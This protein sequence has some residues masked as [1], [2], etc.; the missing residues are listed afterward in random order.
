MEELGFFFNPGRCIGCKACQ[1]A[2]KDRN[3]L[4]NNVF[5]RRADLIVPSGDGLPL[6][7][8]GACNHCQEPAC[9]Q[10][11][12]TGAMY[13]KSDETTVH[14][15]GKCIG[16]GMCIWSCPYG[17]PAFFAQSGRANKC[18]SCYE[19]RS[20]GRQPICTEACVTG[21]LMF[22]DLDEFQ[23]QLGSDYKELSSLPGFLPDGSLTNPRLMVKGGRR[24]L[25]DE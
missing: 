16:C 23:K 6:Y 2:C 10:V 24:K 22:G 25:N 4:G 7:Y 3:C 18:D 11:C 8:S 19:L 13:M 17:A 21:S 5:F 1:A 20:E 9:S 12:P 14:D 15:S